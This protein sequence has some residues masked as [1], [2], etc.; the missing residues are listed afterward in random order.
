MGTK[1]GVHEQITVHLQKVNSIW[2]KQHFAL[3]ITVGVMYSCL[4]TLLWQRHRFT[5]GR[6]FCGIL[7]VLLH[8]QTVI[9]P[10]QGVHWFKK[11][12]IGYSWCQP[13]EHHDNLFLQV[14]LQ[15]RCIT[16]VL[17]LLAT[18]HLILKYAKT[19]WI[20]AGACTLFQKHR[21]LK[22]QDDLHLGTTG[23][24]RWPAECHWLSHN[25]YN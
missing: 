13:S 10:R 14:Q 24:M 12:L 6:S 19:R 17:A 4:V 15:S 7:H 22:P 21:A 5:L 8:L 18:R 1:L 23:A 25:D 11:E 3:G 16:A 9:V 2:N 20:C